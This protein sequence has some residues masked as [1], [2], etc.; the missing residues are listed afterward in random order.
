MNKQVDKIAEYTEDE[1]LLYSQTENIDTLHKIKLYLDDLYWNTDQDSGLKDWQY[2]ILRDSIQDRDPNYVVPVGVKI[3][4]NENRVKLPYWLGSMD[5]L[6][7]QSSILYFYKDVE[8]KARKAVGDDHK[9]IMKKVEE[10]WEKLSDNEKKKYNDLSVSAFQKELATWI[11]K[12]QVSEYIIEDKL[13]GV[14]CLVTIKKGKLKL[15][16]RGDGEVGADISYLAQYFTSIPKNLTN[17]DINVRGELIMKKSTF[18]KKY[19]K[20]YANPRNM[21]SGLVGAKTVREGVKDVDF[22]AYEVVGDGTMAKPSEQ[23]EYLKSIGFTTVRNETVKKFTIEELMETFVSFK[24]SSQYEIDGIIVQTNSTYERNT[25][26]NPDYAFAFKM[27]LSG[28]IEE[29]TVVEVEWNVS[30]WGQLKP[31]VRITPVSIGGVT[32]TYTTGFN[33]KYITDNNI[34]TGAII[35]V[36]RSGDVIP[37]IVE[38]VKPAAQPDMPEVSY[39]WNDTGVDIYTEEYGDEMCIKLIANFF[40]KLGIKQV[41]EKNVTKLYEAGFDTLLKIIRASKED[42]ASIPGFGERLA[43][44]TYDNIH[45]GLQ[46]LSLPVVLG[47]SGIF[48]FGLGSKKITTLIDSFPDIFDA[49]KRMS[50]QELLDR[51]TKIEGFSDITAQKIVE[52]I[53]WADLFIKAIKQFGKFEEKVVISDSMKGMTVVFTGFRDESLASKII[54]RGGKIGSSV[55]RNTSVLV[56][57][58]LETKPSGNTKKAMDLNVVILQKADFIKKYII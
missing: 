16:T 41:A 22:V 55:S 34:G 47:A 30:K 58:N 36:T 25:S 57:A 51:I 19:S 7:V 15:F 48:G 52:N 23:L 14:S 13:D 56:V 24:E 43:E 4:E 12:N 9:L 18:N 49:Y 29:T 50:K 26:G 11:F 32:I 46:K 6:S 3:R 31:R 8:N 42:F 2:D 44:R 39:T 40:D 35:K 27:R 53:K 54:E 1:L 21:V 28:N 10:L 33:A 38:V 45:E 5:K 17:I 37:Y 20:N